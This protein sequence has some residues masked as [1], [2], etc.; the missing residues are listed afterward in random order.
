MFWRWSPHTGGAFSSDG[1]ALNQ[2]VEKIKEA[3]TGPT[4]FFYYSNKL[5]LTVQYSVVVQIHLRRSVSDVLSFKVT[6]RLTYIDFHP[7]M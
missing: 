7:I 5:L 4:C 2:Q 1:P 3:V 6:V